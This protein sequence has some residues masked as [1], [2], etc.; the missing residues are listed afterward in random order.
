MG[1]VPLDVMRTEE[2]HAW[3]IGVPVAIDIRSIE[4][5]ARAPQAVINFTKQF[6]PP[7]LPTLAALPVPHRLS[8]YFSMC[9][10][11]RAL[12]IFSRVLAKLAMLAQSCKSEEEE[13]RPCEGGK[14]RKPCYSAYKPSQ[15]L[16]V[17]SGL[18]HF[19]VMHARAL[20]TP[21]LRAPPCRT[22]P[23]ILTIK[24]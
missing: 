16:L 4:A 19:S 5:S 20:P 21:S 15:L 23:A 3:S 14:L 10:H 17:P 8:H 12:Q 7:C 9:N 11:A 24:D 2:L 18:S 22:S 1:G 13:V 6:V